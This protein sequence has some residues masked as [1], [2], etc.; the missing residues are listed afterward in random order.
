MHWTRVP[1]QTFSTAHSS[2]PAVVQMQYLLKTRHLGLPSAN[3]P[4][5]RPSIPA[6][7]YGKPTATGTFR[8]CRDPCG[9]P[10]SWRFIY[11]PVSP[12]H[13]SSPGEDRANKLPPGGN[14]HFTTKTQ[15]TPSGGRTRQ[16]D[17]VWLEKPEVFS[18]SSNVSNK[19][20]A[21]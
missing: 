8:D 15:A 4:R 2:H 3:S 5:T 14:T 11:Q 21:A 9:R 7:I 6:S 1:A 13:L 12:S 10:V 20:T 18:L 19:S 17:C 16:Y